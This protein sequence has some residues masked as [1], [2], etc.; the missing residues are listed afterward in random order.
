MPCGEKK[1]ALFAKMQISAGPEFL[2]LVIL[3]L[4]GFLSLGASGNIF[5]T[6]RIGSRSKD[7]PLSRIEALIPA[8]DI[9]NYMYGS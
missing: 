3:G 4:A 8:Q 9:R 7:G 2:E 6:R 5:G 1:A